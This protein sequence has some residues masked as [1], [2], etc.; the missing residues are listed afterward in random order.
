MVREFFDIVNPI[1][2]GKAAQKLT[3]SLHVTTSVS[4][5]RGVC[6]VTSRCQKL[7]LPHRII[8]SSV[9]TSFRK[10]VGCVKTLCTHDLR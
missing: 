10:H 2:A 4:R 6:K 1:E 3:Q 8:F 9:R 5:A 7:W